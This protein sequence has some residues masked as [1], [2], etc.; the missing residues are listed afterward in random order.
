MGG[1]IKKDEK[2]KWCI[3]MRRLDK[4]KKIILPI[5]QRRVDVKS[6]STLLRGIVIFKL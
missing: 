2:F 1:G 3:K 4:N 5:I 6:R